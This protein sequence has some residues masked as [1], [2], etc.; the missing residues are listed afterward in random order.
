M[1]DDEAHFDHDC[2]ETP[3]APFAGRMRL[4]LAPHAAKFCAKEVAGAR[5]PWSSPG[6]ATRRA[7]RVAAFAR[8]RAADSC[9]RRQELKDTR[10]N[11][12]LGARQS[13]GAPHVNRCAK[14]ARSHLHRARRCDGRCRAQCR[15]ATRG[16]RRRLQRAPRRK[17]RRERSRRGRPGAGLRSVGPTSRQKSSKKFGARSKPLVKLN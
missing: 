13:R 8:A 7:A 17:D 10:E 16:E 3:D 15:G 1:R 4:A 2:V 11:S 14:P 9:A 12:A 6:A 5:A